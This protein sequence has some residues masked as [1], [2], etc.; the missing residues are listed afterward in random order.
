MSANETSADRLVSALKIVIRDSE[1]ILK[2]TA[3]EV[4]LL[5]R[6]K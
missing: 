1:D 2:T 6:K 4:V 3:G 5:L